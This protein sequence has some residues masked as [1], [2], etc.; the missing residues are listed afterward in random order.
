MKE[1]GKLVNNSD[2]EAIRKKSPTETK[3]NAD[4]AKGSQET[5]VT[6][7]TADKINVSERA[8]SV[9]KLVEAVKNLPEIRQEKVAEF[10]EKIAA[11]NYKPSAENIAEAILKDK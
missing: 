1:I 7:P 4:A 11:G 10:R 3:R 9:G 5:I 8:G 6:P 2:L